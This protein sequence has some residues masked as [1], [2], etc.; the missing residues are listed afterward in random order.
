MNG[1]K[2]I[3][4][5]IGLVFFVTIASGFINAGGDVFHMSASTWQ[6][7]VNAG[8][9]AVLAFAINALAPFIPRYG[10]GSK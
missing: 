3:A 8:I 10:L 7:I 5:T 6:T 4:W 2:G 1:W 9:A